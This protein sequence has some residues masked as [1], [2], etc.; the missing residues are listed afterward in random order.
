MSPDGTEVRM[1]YHATPKSAGACDN[2]RTTHAKKI[3][4]DGN[5]FPIFGTPAPTG[6]RL[7]APSGEPAVPFKNPLVNGVYKITAS[8][9]TRPLDVA[10]CSPLPGANVQQWESN[11]ADCQKWH[12]QAT[13]DGYYWISSARGGL[14]LDV[15]NCSAANAANVQMWN[16]TGSDCQKWDIIPNGDGTYRIINKAVNNALDIQFGGDNN[17]ANLQTY[18]YLGNAQQHFRLELLDAG[19][20]IANGTYEIISKRSNMALD[21]TSCSQDNGANII[22]Y[23]RLD[24]D[25]QKW[26]VEDAGDGFYRIIAQ[27]SGKV[28]DIAGCSTAPGA[29]LQQMDNNN[30]DCQKFSLVHVKDGWYS[31]ISKVSGHALDVAGCSTQAGANVQQWTN[32][33]GDCQLWRFELKGTVSFQYFREAENTFAQSAV[34]TE[35]TTDPLGGNLNVGWI[36]AGDWMAYDQFNVPVS[37]NYRFEYRIASPNSGR[38]LSLDLNAGAIQLGSVQVPNTGGWQNWQTITQTVYIQAGNYNLGLATSDG[39]WNY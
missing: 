16:P 32:W 33:Q 31:I 18:E 24:N 15:H 22:Q 19:P 6:A 5:G 11:N 23:H 13:T 36:D 38:H 12:I 2:S 4:F 9:A 25:C 26:K 39:G 29:N 14:A 17:G 3:A 21:L 10:G 27:A 35:P 1:A 28:L 7:Q 37:G 30:S 20:R 34:Q 8:S